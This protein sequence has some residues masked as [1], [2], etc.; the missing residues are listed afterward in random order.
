MSDNPITYRVHL[1]NR[2]KLSS[3]C[4]KEFFHFIHNAISSRNVVIAIIVMYL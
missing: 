1:L 3:L 4:S 2:E